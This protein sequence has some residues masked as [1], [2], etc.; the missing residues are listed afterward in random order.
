ME[1]SGADKD[2]DVDSST[3]GTIYQFNAGLWESS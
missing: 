3:A 2:A 1:G